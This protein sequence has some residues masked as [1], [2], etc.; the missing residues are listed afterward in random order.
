MIQ[1]FLQFLK[2]AFISCTHV[3]TWLIPSSSEL[4][5]E[6]C[7]CVLS[8]RGKQLLLFFSGK[9]QNKTLLVPFQIVFFSF[10][11]SF[12]AKSTELLKELDLSP[13]SHPK[14]GLRKFP[15]K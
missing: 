9:L 13:S 11:Y 14:K 8:S 6:F 15:L 4:L 12:A 1:W 2:T 3:F 10:H 5:I 7:F